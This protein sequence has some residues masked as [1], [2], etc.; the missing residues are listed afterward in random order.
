[1]NFSTDFNFYDTQSKDSKNQRQSIDFKLPDL[2]V[3]KQLIPLSLSDIDCESRE[4]DSTSKDQDEIPDLS[5]LKE[6]QNLQIVNHSKFTFQKKT[7][8]DLS[9]MNS[10]SPDMFT[11]TLQNSQNLRNRKDFYQSKIGNCFSKIMDTQEKKSNV[12][13]LN[14]K[15]NLEND[16]VHLTINNF[17]STNLGNNQKQTDSNKNDIGFRHLSSEEMFLKLKNLVITESKHTGQEK[18]IIEVK[19]NQVKAIQ[20]HSSQKQSLDNLNLN[21]SHKT[22]KIDWSFP[23]KKTLEDNGQQVRINDSKHSALQE[24]QTIC[25]NQNADPICETFDTD[26]SDDD[27][28]TD[29]FD[30]TKIKVNHDL[31]ESGKKT[32]FDNDYFFDEQ[33][34]QLSEGIVQ[35]LK[36]DQESII[37]DSNYQVKDE[38]NKFYKQTYNKGVCDLI[39]CRDNQRESNVLSNIQNQ[40]GIKNFKNSKKRRISYKYY[41]F[42]HLQ[43]NEQNQQ[44]MIQKIENSLNTENNKIDYELLHTVKEPEFDEFKNV[45]LKSIIQTENHETNI[46]KIRKTLSELYLDFHALIKEYELSKQ[47]EEEFMSIMRLCDQVSTNVDEIECSNL[48]IKRLKNSLSISRQ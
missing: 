19:N 4:Y 36:S 24:K 7:N 27:T 21:E 31:L 1:M 22:I 44:K 8:A 41:D 11:E 12:V 16:G 47:N 38:T 3:P 20:N 14:A 39:S 15:H 45:L 13:D 5:S 2:I 29:F 25:G 17:V 48:L 28:Y 9:R 42:T 23:L 40:D 10:G 43:N 33:D 34:G 37:K 32:F 26:S 35:F 46:K 30:N 6:K 18:E